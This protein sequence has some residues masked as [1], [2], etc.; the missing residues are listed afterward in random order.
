MRLNLHRHNTYCQVSQLS[1][2]HRTM[3]VDILLVLLL[4]YAFVCVDLDLC[5]SNDVCYEKRGACVIT[6][7]L[8]MLSFSLSLSFMPDVWHAHHQMFPSSL[9]SRPCIH[10]EKRKQS[11]TSSGE[12]VSMTITA[13]LMSVKARIIFLSDYFSLRVESKDDV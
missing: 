13:Q 6:N 12:I 5:H 11:E 4:N 3:I 8:P 2:T 10:S 9:L 1:P 7:G